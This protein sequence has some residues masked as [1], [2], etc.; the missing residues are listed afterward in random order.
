MLFLFIGLA[1]VAGTL[2]V[3]RYGAAPERVVLQILLAATLLDFAYHGIIGPDHDRDVDVGHLT[4]DSATFAGL[5]WVALRANRVWPLWVC[6]LQLQPLVVHLSMI[7]RLPSHSMA[8]WLMMVVPSNLQVLI[9]VLGA[10]A[11]VHRKRLI[12][13]YR[14]WRL[15]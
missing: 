15:T 7:L 1:L 5:L 10:I 12:G 11:H 9:V 2:G 14:D 6:A 13:P 4:L 3:L 8:Y